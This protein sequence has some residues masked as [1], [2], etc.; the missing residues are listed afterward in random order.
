[1]TIENSERINWLP[2]RRIGARQEIFRRSEGGSGDLCADNVRDDRVRDRGKG[3][4]SFNGPD[5]DGIESYAGL[6]FD[7]AG[8]LY[9]T[10]ISEGAHGG[11]TAFELIRKAGGGWREKVLHSFGGGEGGFQPYGGL[12]IDASGNLYGMTTFVGA[13]NNK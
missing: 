6:I 8:N 7:A 5:G 3:V 12:I 9:G 11:G 2:L 1:M 10:T 13:Y 4:P